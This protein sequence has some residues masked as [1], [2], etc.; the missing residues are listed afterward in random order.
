MTNIAIIDCGLANL[1]SVYYALKYCDSS[2]YLAE[3]AEDLSGA[4]AIVLPGVGAF[5]SFMEELTKRGLDSAIKEMARS[6]TPLLGI[7][8]GMQ[9]LF[10]IGHEFGTHAGL[11]LIS[12][13]VV[14]MDEDENEALKLPNMGW[15]MVHPSDNTSWDGTILQN[16][17]PGAS[18]YFM[19]SYKTVPGSGHNLAVSL[20][21]SETF[22]AATKNG[23]IYGCQ[24]HPEKSGQVGL[25][26]LTNF[27]QL[28][29]TTK[30][31]TLQATG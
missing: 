13:H 8:L 24:F 27:T 14:K 12:G 7:C 2:P 9:I 17:N 20:H 26:I 29:R 30:T 21:G 25:D 5:G 16:L 31:G 18:V 15:R 11:G 10:E 6:S 4:D 23:N 3:K 28:A 22:C 1:Q 19:H